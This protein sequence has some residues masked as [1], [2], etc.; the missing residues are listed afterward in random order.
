MGVPCSSCQ[1][2][3]CKNYD[4]F[5]DHEDLLIQEDLSFIKKILYSKSF[6]YVP[7]FILY[8]EDV[9]KKWVL[10]LNNPGKTC[11]FLENSSEID[12]VLN[13]MSF[14]ELRFQYIVNFFN[15]DCKILPI[16]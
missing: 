5:I 14:L 15:Y 2:N 10:T 4:V 7:K 11:Q 1:A 16:Y 9:A 13:N 12:I 6:G 8:E 3:C